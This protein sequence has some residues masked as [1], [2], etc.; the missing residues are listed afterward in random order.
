[1]LHRFALV[2]AC[3][4]VCMFLLLFCACGCSG[5]FRDMTD[6]QV[7]ALGDKGSA[8]AGATGA[9]AVKAVETGNLPAALG[10]AVASVAGTITA[11]LAHRELKRRKAA[12]TAAKAPIQPTPSDMKAPE[13]PV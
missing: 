11:F 6:D 3:S 9:A 1:M 2:F 7:M 12:R 4:F 13:K 5:L 10:L 8:V